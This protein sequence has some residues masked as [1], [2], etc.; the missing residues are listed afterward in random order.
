MKCIVLAG[1]TGSRL[2]P[3]TESISKQLLPVYDKPLI[4]YPLC[5]AMLAG[6]KDILIISTPKDLPLLSKL[7]DNGS[8]WGINLSY[9]E[10]EKPNGIAEA[11]LIGEKFID[12][13]PVCLILGDNIFYGDGLTARL[14]KAR[15]LKD[16]AILFAHHVP[17]PQ[18][19]GVVSFDENTKPIKFEEKP[20]HPSSNWA[21]S[22]LYFYGPSVVEKAKSL[23]PSPRGELEITDINQQYLEE[24]NVEVQTLG[25][26][27]TWLDTGTPESLLEASLFVRTLEKSQGFKIS[28]PE[29]VAYFKG[30]ISKD[31]L[32]GLAESYGKSTYGEYLNSL[33]K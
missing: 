10:Q 26:G 1:G 31:D 20:E 8:K 21:L 29:E 3:M 4:Y 18:R 5:T 13:Q 33:L 2:Y 14:E 17:D 7:L 9:A 6:I 30:F 22:G 24:K 23:K 15:T 27:Y 16:G 19:Y 11:F 12:G 32:R 25:R 28:C